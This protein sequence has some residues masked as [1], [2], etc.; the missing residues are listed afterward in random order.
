MKQIVLILCLFSCSH[1][2][3]QLTT[4]SLVGEWICKEVSL[5][6]EI[7]D[8]ET[9]TAMDFLKKGFINSRFVFKPDGTLN[10]RLDERVPAKMKELS[11][12]DN[13]KW[14]FDPKMEM[15]MIHPDIM[16]IQ[17]KKGDGFLKFLLS[18]SP[19]SL[20]MQKVSR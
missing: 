1:V 7:T 2:F 3:A 19:L 8:S 14:T 18:D 11:F 10:F 20:R 17:V 9:K 6:E 4:D 12:I 15:I 13:K 5:T 16:D